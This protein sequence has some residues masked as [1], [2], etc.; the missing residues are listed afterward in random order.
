MKYE[1]QDMNAPVAVADGTALQNIGRFV[2]KTVSIT[3]TFTATYQLQGKVIG[4]DWVNIGAAVTAPA[5]VA[6]A[7]SN[8]A[9]L[10]VNDLRIK[11]TAFTSGA[12][13]A[14]FAGHDSR[15]E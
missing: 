1:T 8:G 5:L 15:S 7:D 11:C 14:K 9:E 3:G 4:G 2:H 13:V 12:G 10:A 6:V